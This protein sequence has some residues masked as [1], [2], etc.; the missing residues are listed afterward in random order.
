MAVVGP[1]PVAAALGAACYPDLTA[2]DAGDLGAAVLSPPPGDRSA[3]LPD[4][5]RAAAAELLG[6]LQRWLAA[7][8]PSREHGRLV[9]LTEGALAVAGG[10]AVPALWQA[11]LLGLVRSAQAEHPG[12]ILLVDADAT[13]ATLRCLRA[14][15]TAAIG[16]ATASFD[17]PELAVRDGR[18]LVPRL[19]RAG[20]PDR[21]PAALRPDGTV[22]VTGGTGG[23]GAL[24]ARHLARRHG[25]RRLVLASRRGPGTPGVADL[26]AELTESGASVKVVACDAADRG[27]LARML[28]AIPAEHP[29]TGVVHAAGVL[30]DGVLAALTPQ[31]LDAVLRPKV[32]AAWHLHELTAGLDLAAFV[33]FSSATGTWATAGQAGYAAANSFL[34]SLAAHRAAAGLAASS[35]AWGPWAQGTGMT[36]GLDAG[37]L[38]ALARAGLT[39]IDPADGLALL[40]ASARQA[41]AVVLPMRLDAAAV[42]AG[43]AA[44]GV[45]ALLRTL[46]GTGRRTAVPHAAGR[47]AA[48]P[49][50]LAALPAA[51][52]G[53]ALL[54]LVR[55]QVAAVLGHPDVDGVPAG[56][57]FA[58]LGFDSLTALEFRNRVGAATGLT[59][60]AT[61]IFDHPTCTAVAG[62]L[63]ARLAGTPAQPADVPGRTVA[64]PP[65]VDDDPVVIV[66]MG[67]RFPGGVSSPEELWRLVANGTDAVS[68]FPTDRGWDVDGLYDPDPDRPGRTT[69]RHGGFLYGA[70]EFDAG[71]FGVSPREAAWVDPQ[72]R[73]LLEVAWE[74]VERAGVDPLSLRGSR[75]GVF[76]GVMYHDYPGAAADGSLV[77]GR[78]AYTLGLEG[79]AVSVDTA[80]SSSLVALHLAV[81]ALRRGECSLAL[82]GGVTV[83]ATPAT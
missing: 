1:E 57:A 16:M 70:A 8:Q 49:A 22:L 52:R 69:V 6:H 62:H 56:S 44:G 80:C 12:R 45:P 60:P 47:V 72:Q 33:L 63:A 38:R 82:V 24:V 27:A 40:D 43:A 64:F 31:R 20:E 36:A 83:M 14:A 34:D 71:L 68:G 55:S 73:L 32:D 74:A 67:C 37:A 66:G 76:A 78:V 46:A 13:P 17:E 26:V 39:L 23:L 51:D 21:E 61:L 28:A 41:A 19:V 10:D 2:I 5:A 50:G 11:P 30:D 48:E 9:V 58:D 25:V 75:T 81:Q 42:R 4:L 29:L 59:L 79:P 65:A 7:D 15:I 53:R 3:D 77:S 35:V 54:E 18:V